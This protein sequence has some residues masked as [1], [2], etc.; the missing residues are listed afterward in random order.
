[1]MMIAWL[2]WFAWWTYPQIGSAGEYLFWVLFLMPLSVCPLVEATGIPL[3]ALLV[4]LY[5]SMVW[6][7]FSP[8]RAMYYNEPQITRGT[9]VFVVLTLAAHTVLWAS[10]RS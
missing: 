9:S 8:W 4:P 5:G 7:Y 1:M 3:V 2:G 6:L 10:L